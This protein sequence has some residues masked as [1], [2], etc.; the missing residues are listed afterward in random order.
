MGEQY[1]DTVLALGGGTEP[2]E[3]WRRF[4]GREEVDVGALLKNLGL[5]AEA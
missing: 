1:R 2:Q 4:R 3:V 5:V